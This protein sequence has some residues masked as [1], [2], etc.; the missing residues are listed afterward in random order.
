M[1]EAA[2]DDPEFDELAAEGKRLRALLANAQ[3]SAIP[4]TEIVETLDDA[5]FQGL[6]P[7]RARLRPYLRR[8]IGLGVH[9]VD[10]T[11]AKRFRIGT[12]WAKSEWHEF[13]GLNGDGVDWKDIPGQRSDIDTVRREIVGEALEIISQTVFNKTYFALEETGLG[14]PTIP[15]SAVGIRD[16]N[17]QNVLAAYV[18]VLGDS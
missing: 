14:Y 6:L 13:F 2:D 9:P 10:G 1:L 8:F 15:L 4:L 3:D 18:R 16:A 17:D 11:G 12:E 5:S 7:D